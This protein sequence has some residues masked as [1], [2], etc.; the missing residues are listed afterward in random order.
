[1]MIGCAVGGYRR[2][3]GKDLGGKKERFYTRPALFPT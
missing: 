3:T 1:M 2:E